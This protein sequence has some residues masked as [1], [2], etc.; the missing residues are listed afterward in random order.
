MARAAF[1]PFERAYENSMQAIESL[2]ASG[3]IVVRT[4]GLDAP[5]ELILAAGLVPVRLVGSAAAATPRAD[6][7]MG[8]ASM[9]ARGK[10]LLEQLVDPS[11]P[12]LPL[13]ITQ[14]DSEQPQ[15]FAA[16]R[17]L[18]RL[19][20]TVPSDIH[21]LDLLHIERA[22]SRAYNIRRLEQL[23]DWLQAIS[24]QLPSLERLDAAK[25]SLSR[26]RLL[27]ERL[28]RARIERRV[29]GSDALRIIGASAVLPVEDHSIHLESLLGEVETLPPL[30]GKPIYVTGTAHESAALYASI[31]SRGAIIVGEDHGWGSPFF[32]AEPT[33]DGIYG[34]ADPALRPVSRSQ[35]PARRADDMALDV[36]RSGAELVLHL[37]LDGDEAAPWDI[38]SAKSALRP[39]IRFLALRSGLQGDDAFRARIEAFLRGEQSV[40]EGPA[41]GAPKPAAR[42]AARSRKSLG[43]VAAFGAYQRE[44]FARIRSEVANGAPFAMTNANA[45]QEILRAL[46]MPF[47]VNQ[48]WASIVAA[49]QQSRRYLGL[50]AEHGYPKDVEAYSSQ[51][52]AALFDGEAELAPWGGLPKPDFLFAIASSDPTLKIFDHWA[53][54]AGAEAFVY[55]RTVDPRRE[56]T[57]S[58]WEDLPERWDEALEAERI[59]LMVAELETV[60]GRIEAKTGRS[61]SAERFAEVMELVNSQEEY[62]RRTRDLI[63]RTI[64]APIGIVDSMPATMVPQWHR[65]TVWARDAARAFYEEVR[66]R[67]DAGLAAAPNERVRLMFVGRGLWSDMGFYQKW[68]ESH[69]A[70]FVWSM[71]LALAADGYIRSTEGGRDPMRALAARF[72]TMGDELRMPTWAGPWHVHEAKTHQVDGAVA[73]A[74]A[75]PFVIR[76]LREAGVPV[77][78]LSAD[79]FNREGEDSAAIEA[80]ITA[81]IEGPAGARAQSRAEHQRV[82]A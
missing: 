17:E 7:I 77:L 37:S 31:E 40:S 16:L 20:E 30:A 62:Y 43:S 51:G 44:W 57:T 13:L 3:R 2:C 69:G 60:I 11:V 46:D 70:V 52:L 49:K 58:W 28:D 80:S 75:D 65:G 50:L 14:A 6:S 23:A 38:A 26:H 63:A 15:I 67:V 34:L 42:P 18:G 1:E 72:L 24:G 68:E 66:A 61:F 8:S 10:R 71:Y 54:E 48:W 22:S 76:A 78:E 56:I 4:L 45:P 19:G 82:G 41:R 5:R 25:Q 47:V 35:S 53:R 27:L 64:P 12:D 73:L 79:N 74:D 55:E 9:G 39:N 36:A 59:D 32:R 81:F 33:R 21:F 29:S